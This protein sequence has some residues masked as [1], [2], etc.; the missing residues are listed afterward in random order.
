[1]YDSLVRCIQRTLLSAI[2]TSRCDHFLLLLAL[3][4]IT[5]TTTALLLLPLLLLL[6]Q[7]SCL[8]SYHGLGEYADALEEAG[9]DGAMLSDPALHEQDLHAMGITAAADRRTLFTLLQRIARE[10]GGAVPSSHLQDP[11]ACTDN[12]AEAAATGVSSA[13]SA[14]AAFVRSSS[15]GVSA[16][17][18]SAAAAAGGGDADAAPLKRAHSLVRSNSSSSDNYDLLEEVHT[19]CS[20]HNGTAVLLLLYEL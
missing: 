19:R 5:I 14:A 15:S 18:I 1:V 13:Y 4:L 7:V 9:I 17:S 8:L 20:S 6:L 16:A 2:L 3:L 10:Q 11:N 12:P